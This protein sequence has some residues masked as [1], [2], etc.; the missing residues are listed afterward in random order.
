MREP[1]QLS[2][3]ESNAAEEQTAHSAQSARLDAFRA[4]LRAADVGIVDFRI[5]SDA[6]EAT[7]GD[8]VPF[9]KPRFRMYFLHKSNIANAWL[10]LE[11]QSNGTKQLVGLA[12]RLLDALF[13]GSVLVIDELERSFHPLLAL[14]L[15]QTFTNPKLNPRNAQLIFST[16]DTN[17]LGTTLGEPPLRRD[18]IWLTE[19]DNEGATRIYPLA[20]FK[21]RKAENLERGYLQGRYGAIPFLGNIDLIGK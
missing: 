17:L 10:P 8:L 16:H 5:Q 15:V 2:L 4:L 9:R 7:S 13:H 21:P 6:P 1:A 14:V 11:Q 3:F 18:Q 12:P 19:K 20:D